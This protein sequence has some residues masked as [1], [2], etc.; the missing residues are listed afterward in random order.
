[1]GERCKGYDVVLVQGEDD[2]DMD[3]GSSTKV[4]IDHLRIRF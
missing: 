2:T 3:I 1:M 4:T